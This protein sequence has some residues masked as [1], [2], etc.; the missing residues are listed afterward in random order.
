[1]TWL[2]EDDVLEPIKTVGAK[3]D[4]FC[5][6]GVRDRA[7]L[8][9]E[10]DAAVRVIHQFQELANQDGVDIRLMSGPVGSYP[11]ALG[12]LEK[13]LSICTDDTWDENC[14][15]NLEIVPRITVWSAEGHEHPLLSRFFGSGIDRLKE[16]IVNRQRDTG[17]KAKSEE[18][19]E[20]PPN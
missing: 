12:I 3:D 9:V 16:V 18:T 17:S 14:H 13:L 10:H 1:M 4:F 15:V 7:V 20:E 2:R 8:S 6:L 11:T 19:H 5:N